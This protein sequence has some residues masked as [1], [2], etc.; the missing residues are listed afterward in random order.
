MYSI[1]GFHNS[2]ECGEATTNHVGENFSAV[3]LTGSDVEDVQRVTSAT[4]DPIQRFQV[5]TEIRRQRIQANQSASSRWFMS[6]FILKN[7][8]SIINQSFF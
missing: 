8:K 2:I 6:L 3:L 5:A 1:F 4:S 7:Q